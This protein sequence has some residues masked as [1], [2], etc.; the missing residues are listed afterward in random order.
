MKGL[1]REKQPT[2][3]LPVLATDGA[4]KY[5]FTVVHVTVADINDNAPVFHMPEYRTSIYSNFTVNS[6]FFKVRYKWTL[7][8]ECAF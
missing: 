4:G 2:Y 3:E 6:S 8:E 5:D 7:Y 1:D